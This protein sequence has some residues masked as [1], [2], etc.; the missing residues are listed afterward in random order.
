MIL[1]DVQKHPRK[2][3]RGRRRAWISGSVVE[4]LP[5]E[6]QVS[7]LRETDLSADP[8]I[9]IRQHAELRAPIRVYVELIGETVDV[10]DDVAIIC[11]VL[12]GC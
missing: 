6:G 7:A 12:G 3:P 8:L 10:V 11:R 1:L 5:K 9:G 2:V 4:E